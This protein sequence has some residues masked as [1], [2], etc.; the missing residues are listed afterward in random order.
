MPDLSVNS[1]KRMRP[2]LEEAPDQR[3]V[4][5]GGAHDAISRRMAAAAAA[6]S[7]AAVIG[8]PTTR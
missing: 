4:G 6:G 1:P 7:G 3:L 2:D 5:A 8:R